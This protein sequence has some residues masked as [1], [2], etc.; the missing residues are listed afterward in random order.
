VASKRW[1]GGLCA[2]AL[3]V[4]SSAALA[5]GPQRW[6]RAIRAIEARDAQKPPPRGGVAL[7]GS[8]SAR[9][10]NVARWFPGLPVANRGFGG[11]QIADST[12][13]ADR[14]VIPLKP[15]V[16]VLYAGDNDIAAGKSPQRVLE[17]FKA[18]VAKIHRALPTTTIIFISIKPSL[19]R[20]GLYPKMAE[21]NRLIADFCK[22]DDR[23]VFLD[24]ATPM[25]GKD[26]KPRRELFV[27]DGLHLNDRGYELWTS[28]LLPRLKAC[29]GGA[30][31]RER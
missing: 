7:C 30:G 13:Y 14:I 25:L 29:L 1:I 26:G 4:G 5:G 21:A 15:R 20:W 2:T 24:V 28:L 22:G 6:E 3:L 31:T 23:L 16:V 9:G 8:S 10:W 11:S 27:A 17:D 18:F 12:H 19:R